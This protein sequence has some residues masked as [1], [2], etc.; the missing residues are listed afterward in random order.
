MTPD[1]IE[2]RIGTLRLVDGVP[3]AETA[4]RVY[5]NLDF[6]RGVEVFLNFIPAASLE[7]MRLGHVEIGATRSQDYYGHELRAHLLRPSEN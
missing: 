5:D 6:L 3:T 2:T 7:A 4:Q 1:T